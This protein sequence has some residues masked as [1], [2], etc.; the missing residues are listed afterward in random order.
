MAAL[1]EM[2]EPLTLQIQRQKNGLPSPIPLPI[3]DSGIAGVGWSK[4]E[5][6]QIDQGWLVNEWS[7]GGYYV[8]TVTDD[9]KPTPRKLV[10]SPYWDP[11]LF[12]EKIPPTL[13]SAARPGMLAQ[14][15][16][17]P[18]PNPQPALIPQA[19]PQPQQVP[20]SQFPGGLPTG[21]M[22]PAHTPQAGYAQPQQQQPMY[23]QPQPQGYQQGY[24]Q[25]PPGWNPMAAQADADRR[26]L[27]E[28]LAQ[29]QAAMRA[30]ELEAVRKQYA[31]DL[32]R[33]RN[34]NAT[35]IQRLEQQIAALATS[36]TQSKVPPE[37]EAMRE[38]MRLQQAQLESERRE[39]E[40]ERRER[41]MRELV[42]GQNAQIQRQ[43]E[44]MQAQYQM[45][46]QAQASKGPDPFIQ[47]LMEQSRNSMEAM[48]EIARQSSTAID[49]FQA[50]MMSPRDVMSITK[51]ASNGLDNVTQKMTQM[52]SG[53]FDLQNK[54]IES[55]MSLN[56]GGNDTVGLIREGVTNA[57]DLFER[58][59]VSKSREAQVTA[60]A[61]SAAVQAQAQAAA[62]QAQ[63][64]V[65]TEHAR[66]QPTPLAAPPQPA[67]PQPAPQA[68]LAG[69]PGN[70][71]PNG[72]AN[73]NGHGQSSFDAWQR[74]R[75]QE[76]PV[77]RETVHVVEP[78]PPPQPPPAQSQAAPSTVEVVQ[79]PVAKT[80]QEWF[81]PLLPEVV[82]LR[83]S[84]DLFFTGLRK[85]PPV[86]Q[87]GS[88]DPSAVAKGVAAAMQAVMQHGIPI[89]ALNEL[90]APG[91]FEGFFR[92]LLPA[93][94][95]EFHADAISELKQLL[96][97]PE[98]EPDDNADGYE[99]GDHDD[100]RDG[101]SA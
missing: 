23:Y 66:R 38:Q 59:I 17:Q 80:D 56:Q 20:M 95:E 100:V 67:R 86:V 18:Q 73:G 42:A 49:K 6:I 90:L 1:E 70:G 89:P 93:A 35:L 36:T 39:R 24:Q 75:Q 4:A 5:V 82:N 65:A 29:M 25:P 13:V 47:M 98:D 46:M 79:Q 48:K 41:E 74:S 64:R 91:D 61:N 37:V 11:A 62:I 22:L 55:A 54:V 12:P 19:S 58:Y 34:A 31:A 21:G 63:A 96:G 32:E 94:T 27:E 16:P 43:I 87:P 30:V 101:A 26:R 68:G 45:M 88:A 85:Q 8:I 33:E 14:P 97:V 44:A 10:W 92:V 40:A 77:P 99:D 3:G 60:Q 76:Q 28:Q 72:H 52:F 83:R 57:K 53:V 69:G 7:G 9:T 71:R 84:V 50:F 51:D 2:V 81:G 78:P 15:Q